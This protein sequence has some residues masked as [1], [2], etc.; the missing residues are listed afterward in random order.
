MESMISQ[1]AGSIPAR[2]KRPGKEELRSNLR[3]VLS[4]ISLTRI[5]ERR[6]I[7][8]SLERI[9]SLEILDP[10]FDELIEE[11]EVRWENETDRMIDEIN[12]DLDSML[13]EF[14]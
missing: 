6:Q 7:N 8:R 3:N 14:I 2:N 10:Y 1:D 11:K 12:S 5:D 13:M 9:T 4:E